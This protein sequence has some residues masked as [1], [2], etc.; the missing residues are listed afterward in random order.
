MKKI[1]FLLLAMQCLYSCQQ[2]KNEQ[3]NQ[4]IIQSNVQN[5][6]QGD[7]GSIL[8]IPQNAL[9]YEDGPEIT[10]DVTIK[11]TEAYK[12]KD[13]LDNGLDTRTADKFL[14]TG[15]GR[16]YATDGAGCMLASSRL[17][18]QWCYA[19]GTSVWE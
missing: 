16:V 9:V 17:R 6:I 4:F 2:V 11:L 8:I 5:I 12:L 18:Y 1:L 15:A 7:Q 3:D 14:V 10:E 19:R 13:I